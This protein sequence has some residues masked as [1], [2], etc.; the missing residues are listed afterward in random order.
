[1]RPRATGE[2]A[3]RRGLAADRLGDLLEADAE[4]VVQQKGG[5]LERRQ[6]LERD[7]QRQRDVVDLVLSGFDHGFRQPGS[8]IGLAPA[9]RRLQ[10]VEAEAGDDATQIGFRLLHRIAIGVEP[11]QERV[12]HR[13]LRIRDRSQHAIGDANQSRTQRI[14]G[15]GGIL[16]GHRRHHA[17][18]RSSSGCTARKPTWMRFHPLMA[19]ISNVS[20]TCSSSLNCALSAR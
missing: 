4:H 13:V 12:L 5:A 16:A 7:H 1:M 20:A 9:P 18:R 14:E 15:C 10:L 8:D 17:A 3:A 2:L 19:T 6:A 11:A